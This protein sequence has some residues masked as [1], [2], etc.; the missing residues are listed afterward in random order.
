[1][2]TK[3]IQEEVE[4]DGMALRY[5]QDRYDIMSDSEILIAALKQNIEAAQYLRED[6]IP[7]DVIQW[8]DDSVKKNPTDYN[9]L[10][11]WIQKK[12]ME[13]SPPPSSLAA[14]PPPSKQKSASSSSIN[15]QFQE[16]HDERDKYMYSKH[17]ELF[18]FLVNSNEYITSCSEVGEMYARKEQVF[19]TMI[20]KYI[21]HLFA[22]QDYFKKCN[23]FFA[24]IN[25]EE[26]KDTPT[27][28]FQNSPRLQQLLEFTDM[29]DI[30][31]ILQNIPLRKIVNTYPSS[32]DISSINEPIIIQQL[33]PDQY[34]IYIKNGSDSPSF[35]IN[36]ET[37]TIKADTI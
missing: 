7:T 26:I 35:T 15:I 3:K 16:L 17:P 19:K 32:D 9:K 31:Q 24:S 20:Q 14:P 28:G 8:L 10:P 36:E 18:T 33:S 21:Q 5:Y 30:T 1:M 6:E 37:S 11:E 34:R 12:L 2:S 23:M 4:Q 29:D 27:F 22:I 25:V 13:I